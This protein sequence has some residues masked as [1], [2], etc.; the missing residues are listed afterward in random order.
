MLKIG[1]TGN[2]Y[3]GHNEV[4]EIFEKL[5]V[6]VFDADLILKYLINFSEPHMIKIRSS[7]GDNSYNIGLLNFNKF[8]TNQKWNELLDL[9]EFDIIKSYERFRLLHKDDFYTVFKYSYIFERSL[10]LSMDK[11]ICCYRP[12][13]QR[14]NDLKNLTYMDNQSIE[15]LF[16]NE[17]DELTKNKNS[18]Y[19]INNFNPLDEQN[20]YIG[21]DSKVNNI[22]IIIMNKKPQEYIL[23]SSIKSDFC[24]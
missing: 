6:K 17:M 8:K 9:L 20:Y 24:Y 23:G 12:K 18:D 19:T 1:L 22:H 3:S 21:L 11:T 10:N 4:A 2:Y 13:Y 15:Y 5:G 16:N 7:L 14:R